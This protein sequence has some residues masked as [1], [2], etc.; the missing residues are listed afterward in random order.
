M[1]G[2]DG[3]N[4]NRPLEDV[5]K[6]VLSCLEVKEKKNLDYEE[7][8]KKVVGKKASKHT[9]VSFLRR[10]RLVVTVSNSTWLYRLTLDRRRFIDKFNKY[11]KGKSKIREIQ[12]RI[13]R[14]N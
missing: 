10:G 5:I 9:K 12:F 2:Q 3:N 4:R 14:I 13:G 11:I 6:N 1:F 8:W 7:T